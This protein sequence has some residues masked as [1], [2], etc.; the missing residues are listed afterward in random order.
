MLKTCMTLLL[1]R[2]SK[3]AVC[4]RKIRAGTGSNYPIP[5][6][7]EDINLAISFQQDAKGNDFFLH[8][9]A[10]ADRIIFLE[11]KPTSAE[12]RSLC[13]TASPR[14]EPLQHNPEF[15]RAVYCKFHSLPEVLHRYSNDPE[16]AYQTR[17]LNA[18]DFI[19]PDNVQLVY[20]F[21]IGEPFFVA[22]GMQTLRAE[23]TIC[24]ELR[25]NR[26]RTR[27]STPFFDINLWNCYHLLSEKTK[28][29]RRATTV[30]RLIGASH[31]CWAL[32]HYIPVS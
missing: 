23:C 12:R 18:L 19:A 17:Q 9:G 31:L 27:L 1:K 15:S 6:T 26:Q 28:C 4:F 3:S 22:D 2:C 5:H 24:F 10:S 14:T 7:R 8:L 30:S 20:D 21:L 13:F 11:Q 29:P 32:P 16:F 25:W